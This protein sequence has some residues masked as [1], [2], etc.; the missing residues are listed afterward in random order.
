MARS[1]TATVITELDARQRRPCI[2]IELGLS[3][4]LYYALEKTNVVFPTG[5]QTYTAKTF[6]FGGV[7][8]SAEGQIQGVSLKIS[9]VDGAFTSYANLQDFNGKTLVIKK[10]FLNQLASANDYIELFRGTMDTPSSIDKFWITIPASSGKYLKNR[11]LLWK[12][13]KL[14]PWRFGGT[15]CNTDSLADLTSLTATGTADSGSTTTLVDNALT[16]A[17]DYWNFGYISITIS[18]KVYHRKVLNFIASSDTVQFDVALPVPVTNGC[19]YTIYKGCDQTWSCC[20]AASAFG[21]SADNTAN[22]G[23]FL[24]IPSSVPATESGSGYY[25]GLASNFIKNA[26]SIMNMALASRGK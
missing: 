2:L 17:D 6:E 3:S 19:A 13:T 16:Q 12:Y 21:P 22:F 24:H 14:C 25:N 26:P 23:G 11:T 15:E 5:G 1:L 8:H 9:N 7:Q 10:V 4:T 18:G 20:S